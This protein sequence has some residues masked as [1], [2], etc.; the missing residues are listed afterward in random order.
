MIILK[1]SGRNKPLLYETALLLFFRKEKGNF[2]FGFQDDRKA[3]K[4]SC[5]KEKMK[6]FRE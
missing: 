6:L 1:N 5:E 3:K 4:I 2:V